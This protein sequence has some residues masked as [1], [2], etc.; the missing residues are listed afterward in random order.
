VSKKS[1]EQ[2]TCSS[3]G[4][5]WDEK[6]DSRRFYDATASSYE[7]LFGEEQENK[8]Q[9]AL[10]TLE[11]SSL[12]AVLDVGCG[13]ATFLQK[14]IDVSSLRVGIDLSLKMLSYEAGI[15]MSSIHLLCADAD[16]LPI[17]CG[18][19]DSVFAFTLLQNMP[20]PRS[21][22]LEMFRVLRRKGI[23]I[24]T[25]P[26]GT[27]LLSKVSQWFK[28]SGMSFREVEGQVMS[29]DHILICR[30]ERDILAYNEPKPF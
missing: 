19:F 20:N 15:N 5:K 21:T 9:I 30:K 11:G 14:I 4:E 7:E 24:A 18:I 3:E 12:G 29:K 16:Y 23:I 26:T 27:N 28:D 25:W 8:Y 10:K 6:T 13:A 1:N 2:P 17:R 22:F